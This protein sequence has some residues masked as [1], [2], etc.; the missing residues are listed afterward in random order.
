[1]RRQPLA[2]A[3]A[4]LLCAV[5]GLSGQESRAETATRRDGAKVYRD[6]VAE[7]RRA[8]NAFLAAERAAPRG[9]S[10]PGARAEVAQ[11]FVPRFAEAAAQ[12]AG[13]A[14]AIPLLI[15]VVHNDSTPE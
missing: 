15:W 10:K 9:E 2:V 12:Q 11:R 6:L 1:M 3:F 13:S 7:Y 5:A 4:V 8:D 14:E